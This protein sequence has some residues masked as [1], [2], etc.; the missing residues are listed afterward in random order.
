[1]MNDCILQDMKYDIYKH[2]YDIYQ[3]LKATY[4]NV[5]QHGYE[6]LFD[7]HMKTLVQTA[8]DEQCWESCFHQTLKTRTINST[9]TLLTRATPWVL[10]RSHKHKVVTQFLL[11]FIS[12]SFNHDNL[13]MILSNC[14][15]VMPHPASSIYIKH[16]VCSFVCPSA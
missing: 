13:T 3:D 12:D 4:H 5:E 2:E 7:W 8:E 15:W 9:W 14:N 1:M 10:L 16:H 6:I 11:D